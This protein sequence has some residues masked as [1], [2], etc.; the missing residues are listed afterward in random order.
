MFQT[1]VLQALLLLFVLFLTAACSAGPAPTPAPTRLRIAGSTS[2][3]P[4]LREIA[5]AFQAQNPNVLLEVQGG[6]TGNGWEDLRAGRAE[7]AAL[8]WWDA[9]KAAPPGYRLVPVARDGIAIVV[10]PRNPITNVT[11]LQL[12]SLFG[13]EVLDWSGL[14]GEQGEPVIVS[15]EEGSGT[16]AAFESRIMG[17]RR[18]TLNALVMPTTRAVADYVASHRLAVGYLSADAAD[19]RVR[20]VPVEG[21]LPSKEAIGSGGYHLT[22]TLYLAA[23]EPASPGLQAFL[24]FAQGP[25]GAAI[26]DKHY[27]ALR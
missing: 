20:V 19:S 23:R 14:G 13:G 5:A 4:A 15:R 22:R 7:V 24:D 18:V 6:D 12:R 9:S 10:H 2:M 26:W 25:A 17:D 3:A 8:S 27:A 16:R 21:L 1:A 11:A